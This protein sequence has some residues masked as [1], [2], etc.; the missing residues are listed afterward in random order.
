[1]NQTQKHAWG[2]LLWGIKTA[3]AMAAEQSPKK[4]EFLHSYTEQEGF[5]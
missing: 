2:I 1:M 5:F 3:I 4:L